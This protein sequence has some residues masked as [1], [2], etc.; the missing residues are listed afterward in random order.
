MISTPLRNNP[1]LGK[2]HIVM[3]TIHPLIKIKVCNTLV[4]INISMFVDFESF[5]KI[6]IGVK[7]MDTFYA[8][9]PDPSICFWYPIF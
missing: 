1:G 9:I 5:G 7:I 4:H 3:N 6:K 8:Y 2:A